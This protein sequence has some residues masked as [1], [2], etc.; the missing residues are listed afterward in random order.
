VLEPHRAQTASRA[1]SAGEVL[2]VHDTTELEFRGDE[3]R[4]G[5]GFLRTEVDQGFLLHVALAVSGDGKRRPLGVIASRTWTRT[6]RKGARSSFQTTKDESSE[7]RR[8]TE[9]IEEVDR[10]LAELRPIHVADRE[11]DSFANLQSWTNEERRFVVRA[12]S[13]RALLDE[14]EEHDG[15][16]SEAISAVPWL[17]QL[18]VPLSR[19]KAGPIPSSKGSRDERVA[20]LH[21][22]ATRLVLKWPNHTPSARR[23]AVEVNVVHAVEVDPP[24]GTEPV[25]WVLY[26]SEPV[27]SSTHALRILEIYRTRWLVEELFKALKT[28]CAIEKRQLESYEAL[29]NAAAIFIPIA[30]RALA[31]RAI[32]RAEPQAPALDVLSST[33]IAV[34]RAKLPKLIPDQPTV[35]DALRAVAYLGG[36][37][38]KKPPGW[39]VL[40]RGMEDLLMLEVGWLLARK[41]QATCG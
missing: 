31:L 26:T 4:E 11:V 20:K 3:R 13:D 34:L 21:V 22:S 15:Y 10:R 36:H 30:W 33:Q 7:G 14:H 24:N 2:V 5:L 16:A 23:S 6:I 37:F 18:D 32:H 29:A 41:Q 25:S 19:R 17:V 8:W 12:R 35:D 38:I 39:Q 27:S 40:C 28:G 1:R 9:Q